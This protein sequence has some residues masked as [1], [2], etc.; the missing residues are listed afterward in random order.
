MDINTVNLPTEPMECKNC[1]EPMDLWT[2]V[3]YNG[4]GPWV[5]SPW[6]CKKCGLLKDGTQPKEIIIPPMPF[7]KMNEHRGARITSSNKAWQDDI[8]HR[9]LLPN[10]DVAI[11]ND[12]G[13]IK[14]VRP[15]GSTL[16]NLK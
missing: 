6:A 12:K 1:H 14:E 3:R 2:W 10:G 7:V 11:V 15:K 4:H 9:R 5:K 8:A 16:K 13:Q